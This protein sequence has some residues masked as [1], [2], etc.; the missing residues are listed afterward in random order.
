MTLDDVGPGMRTQRYHNNGRLIMLEVNCINFSLDKQNSLG[1]I[2]CKFHTFQSKTEGM[3]AS[4]RLFLEHPSYMHLGLNEEMLAGIHIDTCVNWQFVKVVV[5]KVEVAV[6]VV[7]VVVVV[8][9]V[10][11]VV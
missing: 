5:V 9:M 3:A 7:A 2:M 10:V 1:I 4:V 11:V 6:V 8:M